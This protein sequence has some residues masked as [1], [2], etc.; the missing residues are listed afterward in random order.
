MVLVVALGQITTVDAGTVFQGTV[1]TGV[2]HFGSDDAVGG[3]AVVGS[4]LVLGG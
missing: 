3:G 1:V 4:V 2:S